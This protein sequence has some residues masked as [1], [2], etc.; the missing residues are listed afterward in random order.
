MASINNRLGSKSQKCTPAS[1]SD[2][3]TTVTSASSSSWFS[4]DF[5]NH[6]LI[7]RMIKYNVLIHFV[8]SSLLP[9]LLW[10]F[11]PLHF[12]P[13]RIG[14][15]N[16]YLSQLLLV[17]QRWRFAHLQSA[18]GELLPFKEECKIVQHRH[19]LRTVGER[20]GELFL[21]SVSKIMI[22]S[23]SVNIS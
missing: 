19:E 6:S 17:F 8:Q 4:P 21:V 23:R 20:Y 1:S 18:T 16:L 22:Y 14:F 9:T 7:T 15:L 13:F 3:D 5:S 10:E 2:N 11:F 12:P